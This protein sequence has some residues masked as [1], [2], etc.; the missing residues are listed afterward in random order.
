M[1][2]SSGE[3]AKWWF[4]SVIGV[5]FIQYAQPQDYIDIF[6]LF[7]PH[8]IALI[9]VVIFLF[10]SRDDIL[11]WKEP[12]V[13]LIEIFFLLSA[14]SIFF[15]L[16]KSIALLYIRNILVCLP[17]IISIVIL[18]NKVDRFKTLVNGMLGI[19][20]V[21]CLVGLWQYD[22]VYFGFG[23]F[24]G[25]PNDFSL[26][27]N[28][29]IPFTYYMLI[30][31]NSKIKKFV[32]IFLLSLMVFVI[33]MS[34]SRGGFLGLISVSLVIWWNSKSKALLS[35]LMVFVCVLI[36]TFA[37]DD[38]KERI[39]FI[40][41]VI[42]DTRLDTSADYRIKSWE[43][44]LRIFK[45]HPFGVGVN[46]TPLYMREY[47]RENPIGED[48][49]NH[50]VWLTALTD[51]GFFGIIVLL[52]LIVYNYYSALCIIKRSEDYFISNMALACFGSLVAFTVSGSFLTVLYYPH[53]WYLSAIIVALVTISGIKHKTC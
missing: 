45:D 27:L 40:P 13:L 50:S 7:N 43:A 14:I 9:P 5:L 28:M 29:M 35:T 52:L 44:S 31:E 38:W 41:D 20:A 37:T 30:S 36:F 34:G 46:N 4:A 8:L 16:D 51:I 24:F 22:G 42:A 10:L 1:I 25:D 12:Q 49:V 19:T 23:N 17:I 47:L 26:F 32:Y 11:Q 18:V 2:T 48:L 6:N 53:I 15:A 33:I 3:Y 39:E 21:L